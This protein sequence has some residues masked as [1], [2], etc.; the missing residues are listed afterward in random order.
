MHHMTVLLLRVPPTTQGADAPMG[1][2]GWLVNVYALDATTPL[3]VATMP[4]V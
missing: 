3:S 1:G 2:T 4:G